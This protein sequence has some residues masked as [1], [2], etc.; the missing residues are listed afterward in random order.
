ME[1]DV[2]FPGANDG[3]VI[4][5]TNPNV[6]GRKV[7]VSSIILENDGSKYVMSNKLTAYNSIKSPTLTLDISY[8]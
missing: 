5:N 3:T 1:V 8:P 7:T 2:Y 6:F 4:L